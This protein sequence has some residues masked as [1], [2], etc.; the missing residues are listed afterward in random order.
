MWVAACCLSHNLPPATLNLK[1]YEDFR[2]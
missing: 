2:Q 1:D